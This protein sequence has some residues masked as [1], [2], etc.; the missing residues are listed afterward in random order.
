MDCLVGR[1][2]CCIDTMAHRP[3]YDRS[4]VWLAAVLAGSVLV[5][6]CIRSVVL[7]AVVVVVERESCSTLRC[8]RRYI[9]AEEIKRKKMEKKKYK[10]V[11]IE[12]R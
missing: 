4:T 3:N 9:A 6:E 10:S 2:H 5:A 8:W 11:T 12:K 1:H 7:V